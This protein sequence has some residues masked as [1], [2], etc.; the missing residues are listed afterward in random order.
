MP[1]T[2]TA[3]ATGT[4]TLTQGLAGSHWQ[5]TLHFP[6]PRS[7]WSQLPLAPQLL[8][9]T[10][11]GTLQSH[12]SFLLLHALHHAS[13]LHFLANAVSIHFSDSLLAP[14]I[15]PLH[16]RIGIFAGGVLAGAAAFIAERAYSPPPPVSPL[17]SL[18]P[19]SL[20]PAAVHDYLTS[21]PVYVLLGASGGAY[22]LIGAE[23]AVI[24]REAWLVL[25]HLRASKGARVARV[26]EKERLGRLAGALALRLVH[27]AGQIVGVASGS[28]SLI[29]Y[30]GHLGGLL[31]G[32][33]VTL[34][35][36]LAFK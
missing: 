20:M 10:A 15:P 25:V 32:F 29:A 18:V 5:A 31:F 27:C 12:P 14:H 1:S 17:L 8:V 28:D 4:G 6:L 2:A 30:S 34:A 26:L 35:G 16:L 24:I 33:T 13:P 19:A 22:A 7:C 11:S 23:I 36:F 3:T 9:T 21:G